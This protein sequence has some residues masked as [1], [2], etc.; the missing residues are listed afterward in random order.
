MS[1]EKVGTVRIVRGEGG[2]KQGSSSSLV[3]KW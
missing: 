2:L 1:E 3:V